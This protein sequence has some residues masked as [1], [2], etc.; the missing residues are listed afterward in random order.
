M[1]AYDHLRTR[2]AF[3]LRRASLIVAGI[4]ATSTA[5]NSITKVDAPDIVQPSE[6]TGEQGADAYYNAAMASLYGQYSSFTY[7]AGVLSDEL[8]WA[9]P[10]DF[11][12]TLDYRTQSLTFSE[13]GP[14]GMHQSRNLAAQAIEARHKYAPTTASKLAELFAIKGIAETVLG[15]TS[16]NGTPLS[17]VVNLTPV[18]GG[19]ITSDSM[20]HR[21]VTDLD[22]A[23]T[24]AGASQR[25]V[26]YAKVLRGRALTD[27]AQYAAAAAAVAGVPTDFVYN[28]EF[29]G[30][31]SV[32]YNQYNFPF[33]W[34]DQKYVTVGDREGGN[35]LDF[36]SANDPRVPT[37]LLGLGSDNTTKV[38]QF[39]K[40]A[41]LTAPIPL[42][43]GIEARLIEAEAALKAGDASWLTILNTLRAT[44]SLAPL[45]DPGNQQ[46]RVLLLFRE[47]AFWLY[48]TGHRAGDLRRLMRQY[49]FTQQQVW[50]TGPYREGQQYGS[51]VVFILTLSEQTN[52]NGHS[53]IDRNP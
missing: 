14:T 38:Y 45:A 37:T 26:N 20:L 25:V 18:Y 6:L 23:L 41:S 2:R 29:N 53:C 31:V 16:C 13:Y 44:V 19:P 52:P 47:R 9:R 15:E 50:P 46:S 10:L 42:A 3:R 48:L 17:D 40:Y 51:D 22:S 30:Q 35:G 39:A 1:N 36:V 28:T 34:Q 11:N 32:N 7:N 8:F 21:A 49:G 43:T 33:Y 4:A 27:R 12:E 24:Y 5:C